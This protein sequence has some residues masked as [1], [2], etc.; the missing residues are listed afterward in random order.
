M[1]DLARLQ[2]G[3]T[4]SLGSA[5]RE[6]IGPDFNTLLKLADMEMYRQKSRY[7]N[8]ASRDRRSHNS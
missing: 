4:A 8:D 1:L 3:T 2:L 7:Y 6:G 5:Y